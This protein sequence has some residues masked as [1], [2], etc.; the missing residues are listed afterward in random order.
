MGTR[1]DPRAVQLVGDDEHGSL[2]LGK[3]LYG[4]RIRRSFFA[5]GSL[6]LQG[7]LCEPALRLSVHLCF[8]HAK[9]YAKSI[10]S[11]L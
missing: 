3:P 2:D 10:T 5:Q 9:K 7:C 8:S 1:V 4:G 6:V 11:E